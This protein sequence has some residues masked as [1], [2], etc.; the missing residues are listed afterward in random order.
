VA[1]IRDPRSLL[2]LADGWGAGRVYLAGCGDEPP[3]GCDFRNG[4]ASRCDRF[5]I[6]LGAVRRFLLNLL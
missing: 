1:R 4:G 2:F 6:A 5:E 3:A